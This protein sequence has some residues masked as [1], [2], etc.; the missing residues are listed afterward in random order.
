MKFLRRYASKD[1]SFLN[2]FSLPNGEN[3]LELRNKFREIGVFYWACIIFAPYFIAEQS[4]HYQTTRYF[5]V[6]IPLYAF[7]ALAPLIYRKTASFNVYA[8]Y[9][10]IFGIALVILL[11]AYEGGNRSPG[12][13]WLMGVP[14]I[15]G[16]VNGS[17]GVLIGTFVMV[18]TFI[19]FL[20]LNYWH[21]LPNLVAEH[22]DY[23]LE[24]LI[25]LVGFGIYNVG[26]SFYFIHTEEKAQ[27][28][29]RTQKQEI[30][31]L[32]RI[33]VHDVATPINAIRLL[34]HTTKT[35][36]LESEEIVVLIDEALYELSAILQQVR[37]LRALKD[38]KW[39]LSLSKVIVQ[40]ALISTINLLQ[41]QADDKSIKFIL[42][43]D[44]NPAW[45]L[46]DETLLKSVI[47]CNLINNAIKFSHSGQTITIYLKVLPKWVEIVFEDQ[48][49]G[50][51]EKLIPHIFEPGAPT[52]RKGTKGEYGTGYGMPL[53]K[54]LITKFCGE[55]NLISS[56]KTELSGTTVII[57]LP[58]V[59]S[60]V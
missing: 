31:D 54:T 7:L 15:F 56:D 48:G 47:F 50:I 41:K 42:D 57:R 43:F 1:F 12:A 37:K 8:T 32:L 25:N 36:Q 5:P 13:F 11:I 23:E 45:V 18:A 40:S 49:I 51:P 10:A 14:L 6:L 60:G 17:R 24:K 30:E 29:L 39:E 16:L 33:L 26:T 59:K 55:I 27:N 22:G 38:G 2:L 44:Q 46:V 9:I 28:E 35:R 21:M 58:V 20:I 34:T 52:T 53:V 19:I 3:N 4:F